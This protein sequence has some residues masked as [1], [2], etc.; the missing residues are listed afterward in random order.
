MSR[1]EQVDL[2]APIGYYDRVVWLFGM[3]VLSY[4]VLIEKVEDPVISFFFYM[5]IPFSFAWWYKTK[6]VERPPVDVLIWRIGLA[7]FLGLG[8]LSFLIGISRRT[9]LVS[10]LWGIPTPPPVLIL[11][12]TMG[13][14]I[15]QFA[16]GIIEEGIFRV[17]IP[18]LL[19][20][21]GIN[22][23][24]VI[25]LS[26]LIFGLFHWNAYGGMIGGIIIATIAGII[27][28]LAYATSRSAIGVMIGHTF[29]NL[30]VSGLLSETLF[31][32][33][34]GLLL[35]GGIYYM[36]KKNWRFPKLAI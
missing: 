12:V 9:G 36:K 14:I 19:M 15:T 30:S 27:Q 25:L 28:S 32:L 31:Y 5:S 33:G 24:A 6:D 35:I 26:A 7:F 29:W 22:S 23:F 16:V 1:T 13:A 34:I 4:L 17:A 21:K 8:L 20:G 2:L 10:V 11:T 18:R 3:I